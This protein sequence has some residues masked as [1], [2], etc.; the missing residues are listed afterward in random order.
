VTAEDDL[1]ALAAQVGE[2]RIDV[3][4]LMRIASLFYEAG[5]SDALGIPPQVKGTGPQRAGHL[6]VVKP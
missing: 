2:L 3:A 4:S 1:A 5:R 6:S